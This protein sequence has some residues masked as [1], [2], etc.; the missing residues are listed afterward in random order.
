MRFGLF[1]PQGWRLDLAGIDT[2]DHWSTMLDVAK[3]A[4]NGPFE[5]MR[6]VGMHSCPEGPV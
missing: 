5:S 3:T 1:V 2:K 4:E 6:T